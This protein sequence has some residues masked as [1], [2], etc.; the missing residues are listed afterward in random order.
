VLCLLV[1]FPF[2]LF[3]TDQIFLNLDHSFQNIPFRHYA[4][5]EIMHG[6]MPLWCPYS[7][8]GFPMFGE[9]QCGAAYLPNW[10]FYLNLSFVQA[11]NYSLI[12]HLL[13]GLI[14]FYLF[15]RATGVTGTAALAGSISWCLSGFFIRRLMFVNFI[16]CLMLMPLLLFAWIKMEKSRHRAWILIAG[17]I[18][19]FQLLAG[20]PQAALISIILLWMVILAGPSG[21]TF[22]HR[23]K[24]GLMTTGIGLAAGVWQWLPTLR[25]MLLSPR[26]PVAGYGGSVQMSFPPAFFPSLILCD[27]FGNAANA[28]FG[29]NWNAYEWEISAYLGSAV[30]V[31][32]LLASLQNRWHRLYWGMAVIGILAALGEFTPFYGFLTQIPLVSTF[33]IP[34]RWLIL[35]SFGLSGLAAGSIHA[36]MIDS[37]KK[38]IIRRYWIK[39]LPVAALCLLGIK[40]ILQKSS[41]VQEGQLD[42]SL[43]MAL[44]SIVLCG[45]LILL[46]K[47][48]TLRGLAG[49]GLVVV[50]YM[51]MWMA[52]F[53]YPGVGPASHV[54][55]P[56]GFLPTLAEETG[57]DYRILSLL[58][59][60]VLPW[61]WH[62][63]WAKPDNGDYR[64]LNQVLPMYSGML[65][66]TDVI[67]FDEWSPLHSKRYTDLLRV[68]NP[69]LMNR[70][71]IRYVITPNR[72]VPFDFPEIACT[73]DCRILLNDRSLPRGHGVRSMPVRKHPGTT[74]RFMRSPA[75]ESS[76][77]ACVESTSMTI[78]DEYPHADIVLTT[79]QPGAIAIDATFDK[80]GLLIVADAYDPGWKA[81]VD[82][83]PA[84][85]L[86]ADHC[87]L[88]VEIRAGNHQVSITYDPVDYRLGL[89][90]SCVMFLVMCIWIVAGVNSMP[91]LIRKEQVGK[92]LGLLGLVIIAGICI[93]WGILANS[94]LWRANFSNWFS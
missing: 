84:D 73:E 67:T 3:S 4:F 34:A 79:Y 88:G 9:G 41:A 25:V 81:V 62:E 23:L 7:A 76:K 37:D 91:V 83:Q 13:I 46:A 48:K 11:Y 89:F 8:A 21:R 61:N 47:R 29:G 85:I 65:F 6:R 63:G 87:F 30:L 82:G 15:L 71:A 38:R 54:L 28:T 40:M 33:R 16:Q 45:L 57:K 42:R 53:G 77:L 49:A 52:G 12:A 60:P 32:A 94:G 78:T 55:D 18:W 80:P 74:L 20:H 51:E 5:D 24:D 59:E 39:I 14:G 22:G 19:G 75:Y 31:L 69:E 27:P 44:G 64:F 10:V 90:I 36:L 86:I 35:L 92:P 70:M 72:P 50:I 1:F 26:S 66:R 68:L 56:P 17:G 93:G 58:H 2:V 43:L